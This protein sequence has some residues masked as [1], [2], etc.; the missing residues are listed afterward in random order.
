MAQFYNLG[1]V[2]NAIR[3][4]SDL[5]GDRLGDRKE[6]YATF[7]DWAIKDGDQH[8][9]IMSDESFRKCYAP[10]DADARDLWNDKL[11]ATPIP[12]DETEVK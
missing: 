12:L 9:M 10:A 3:L 6:S 2:V 8:I 5:A 7:G 11:F 1:A 4:K